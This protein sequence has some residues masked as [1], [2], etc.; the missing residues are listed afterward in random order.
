MTDEDATAAMMDRLG[1][2]PMPARVAVILCEAPGRTVSLEHIAERLRN[3]T[4][5]YPSYG[6]VGAAIKRARRAGMKIE[7][8]KG[9]GW[10]MDAEKDGLSEAQRQMLALLEKTA[11]GVRA[12]A[13]IGVAV[14]AVR[15]DGQSTGNWVAHG[16]EA[17]IVGAVSRLQLVM[18]GG[19]KP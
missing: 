3:M 7:T 16:C 14:A 15:P 8:C 9:M 10:K 6:A 2:G 12:G 4:G 1:C 13:A 17:A 19:A 18:C 11:D 5:E